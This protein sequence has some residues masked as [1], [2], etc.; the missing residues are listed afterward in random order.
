MRVQIAPRESML[1]ASAKWPN[2][3]I[4]GAVRAGTTSL[5]EYLRGVDGVYLSP[6]KEPRFFSS[7]D[8]PPA[9]APPRIRSEAEYLKLFDKAGSAAAIGEASPQ[10]LCDAQAPAAIHAAEPD[11]R[12]IM[13]LRDPVERAFS[14]YLLHRRMGVQPLAAP[15]Q[16]LKND[17]YLKNGLYS[18]A[19]ERYL[20]LFG[21]RGVKVLI[22]DDFVRDTSAAMREVLDLLGVRGAA[23]ETTGKVYN[24][25][26]EPRGRVRRAIYRSVPMKIAARKLFS[27]RLRRSARENLLLGQSEKPAMPDATRAFLES[28]YRDD[29]MKLERVIGRALPWFHARRSA[30]T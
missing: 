6:I 23:A 26:G 2:F 27:D 19:V 29:V 4:V 20:T 21:A 16:A 12:I 8:E 10:Y 15:E 18:A 13:V 11:A 14:H 22:F 3:F 9:Y 28:F 24:A 17:I 7:T 25:Y 30:P 5:Y 1:D